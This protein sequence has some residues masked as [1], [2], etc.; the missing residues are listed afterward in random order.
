VAIDTAFVQNKD[1]ILKNYE[2][3]VLS[4]EEKALELELQL[5]EQI[6]S[7]A[8]RRRESGLWP[9]AQISF[10]NFHRGSAPLAVATL[11]VTPTTWKNTFST[12]F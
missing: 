7:Q 1:V 2:T 6:R 5:F 8:A 9:G 11:P 12:P 4:A 3:R 10:G